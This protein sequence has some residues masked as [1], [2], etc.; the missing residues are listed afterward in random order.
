MTTEESKQIAA[1][2]LAQLGGRRF[3]LMTGSKNLA[4]GNA[5]LNMKL[6]RNVS[7]ATRLT[8]ALSS[9][10]TYTMTFKK[11]NRKFEVLTVCELDH[12]YCDQ[13]Q[14]IFTQI[15]GLYTNL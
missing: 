8:V 9:S 7:G 10:D 1:D 3:L 14:T 13:L 5:S 4:F 6:A 15:T 12:L 11:I 2:I